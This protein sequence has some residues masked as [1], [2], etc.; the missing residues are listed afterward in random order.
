H[1]DVVVSVV[2]RGPGEIV[3]SGVDP[4]ETDAARLDDVHLADEPAAVGHDPSPRLDHEGRLG[5]VMLAKLV[6]ERVAHAVRDALDVEAFLVGTIRDAEAAADVDTLELDAELA[7][8]S[9]RDVEEFSRDDL[10]V[11]LR[12]H[13]ASGHHVHAETLDAELFRAPI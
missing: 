6:V 13:V 5:E 7:A 11:L 2:D 3:H 8:N 10:E 4:H 1:R 9:T 12:E